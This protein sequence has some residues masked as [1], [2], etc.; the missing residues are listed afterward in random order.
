V[1]APTKIMYIGWQQIH[2]FLQPGGSNASLLQP[3]SMYRKDLKRKPI[4]LFI[5]VK[6]NE[7]NKCS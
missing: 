1:L 2:S 5:E 3:K 7:Y 4:C 6:Q